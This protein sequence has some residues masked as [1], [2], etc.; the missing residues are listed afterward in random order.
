MILT[1][2]EDWAERARH[3][4]TQAKV[5]AIE[6]VHGE[7]GYNYRMTNVLAAIGCAQLEN[8]PAFVERKRAVAHRYTEAFAGLPGLEPMAEAPGARSI[9]WMYTILVDPVAYGMD[10]R[11]LLQALGRLKIQARPLWQPMHLSPAHAQAQV[12]GGEVAA[13]LNRMALSIPCSVGLTQADQARVIQAIRHL[14][15]A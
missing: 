5:D 14:G 9:Y 6:F 4:S 13:R 2:R 15:P 1:D 7:V 12:L 8:L 3:L 11:A 10:S